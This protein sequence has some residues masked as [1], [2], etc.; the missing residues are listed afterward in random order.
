MDGFGKVTDSRGGT[1]R[2]SDS[3][4]SLEETSQ[5]GYIYVVVGRDAVRQW[6]AVHCT[7]LPRIAGMVRTQSEMCSRA[8]LGEQIKGQCPNAHRHFH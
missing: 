7:P 2:R 4:A 8:R 1:S 6:G 3:A 5:R